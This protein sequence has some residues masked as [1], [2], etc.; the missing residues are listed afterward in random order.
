MTEPSVPGE[1]QK[2]GK[3]GSAPEGASHGSRSVLGVLG[4]CSFRT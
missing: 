1:E 2:V 4:V 3:G